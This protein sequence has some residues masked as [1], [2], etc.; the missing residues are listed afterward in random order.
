MV[1]ISSYPIEYPKKN[2]CITSV[3]TYAK[4]ILL[5]R[6]S[7]QIQPWQ[8][9]LTVFQTRLQRCV[10]SSAVHSAFSFLFIFAT[11]TSTVFPLMSAVLAAFGVTLY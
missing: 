10:G 1:V 5:V 2:L 4:V 3:P 9:K 8:T 6:C 7:Q 11:S